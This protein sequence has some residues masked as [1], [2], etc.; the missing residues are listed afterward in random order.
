[1]PKSNFKIFLFVLF[2]LI[3]SLQAN[4]SYSRS[5]DDGFRVYCTGNRDSTGV[6]IIQETQKALDCILVPGNLIECKSESEK[7]ECLL[8]NQ[9]TATQAEF[10]C[11]KE[12]EFAFNESSSQESLPNVI[13]ENYQEAF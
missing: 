2:V 1:M 11:N 6:C 3:P 9:I 5:S 4:K 8:E 10:Y 13:K 12:S 7:F